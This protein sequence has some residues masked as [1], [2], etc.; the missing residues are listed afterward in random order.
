M[1]K[2]T[3][4]SI[5]IILVICTNPVF[6]QQFIVGDT[7]SSFI[8]YSNIPD[9]SLP[10]MPQS[11]SEFRIDIDF[12]QIHDIRFYR[13]HTA[14]QLQTRIKHMVYSLDSVQFACT[15]SAFDA[16][17][18]ALGSVLDGK[19]NWN[20]QYDGSRLFEGFY[21]QVPPPW[22]PP[23]YEKG[24]FRKD[25]LFLGFRKIYESDT[26]YGWFCVECTPSTYIIRS[27]AIN[28][29]YSSIP[30]H[31]VN[32][33]IKIYPNPAK[34]ILIIEN[35]AKLSFISIYDINGKGILHKQIF[36]GKTRINLDHLINGLY[37]LKFETDNYISVK[38]IIKE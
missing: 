17:T 31:E 20:D 6:T 8:T 27:Y 4:I 28:R 23:S 5:L 32:A 9:T 10:F 1:K 37:L 35:P 12:D 15:S 14:G 38:K 11:Y 36:Q 3:Y 29:N 33:D 2:I 30:Q 7:V 13:Y 24:L 18:L 16:D 25:S 22:G 19:L 34:D 26:V 21:S